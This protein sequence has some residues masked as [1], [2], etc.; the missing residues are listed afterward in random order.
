MSSLECPS[1]TWMTRIS[2]SC[3]SRCVAKLWRSVCGLTRF[4]MPAA[5]AASWTARLSWRVETGSRE[6]RPGN[7]QPW[8]SMTPR[9]LPSRHQSRSSSSSCG[10]SI[11]LRSLRPLPCSTRISMRVL[12][13][14]PTLRV[15]HLRHAQPG[16]IGGAERGLVLRPRRRLEQPPNLLDAEHRSAACGDGGPGRSGATGPAGRASR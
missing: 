3:S 16:A 1:R 15:G 4:L 11:A 8:G 7:S 13:M 10:D 2:T 6:L 5:S 12:S 14:S 9:R